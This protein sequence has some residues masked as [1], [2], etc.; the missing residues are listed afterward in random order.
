MPGAIR[1]TDWRRQGRY[2][3][4]PTLVLEEIGTDEVA[5]TLAEISAGWIPLRFND[6]RVVSTDVMP[7]KGRVDW[8]F[9][10]S[11]ESALDPESMERVETVL[12]DGNRYE[13]V[14]AQFF[15][16]TPAH[17]ELMGIV[18]QQVPPIQ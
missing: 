1:R 16:G 8:V 13:I 2:G 7:S 12:F 18:S 15:A 11:V 6:E 17:W 4:A 10:I 9:W 5:A 14:S 3:T